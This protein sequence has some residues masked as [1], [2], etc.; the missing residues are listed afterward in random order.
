MNKF[1]GKEQVGGK[2]V[3]PMG[4]YVSTD[5]ELKRETGKWDTQGRRRHGTD[6]CAAWRGAQL[7]MPPSLP[8]S[9]LLA[10][11]LLATCAS[12]PALPRRFLCG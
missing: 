4:R 9:L 5:E 7:Y 1:V 2:C 10:L 8:P 12:P 11:P 6:V 3:R